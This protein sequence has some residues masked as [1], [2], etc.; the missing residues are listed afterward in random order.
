MEHCYSNIS[1]SQNNAKGKKPCT[2]VYRKF[3]SSTNSGPFLWNAAKRNFLVYFP[4]LDRKM[5]TSLERVYTCLFWSGLSP[6]ATMT[7]PLL[8]DPLYLK[9]LIDME[10]SW[11]V[12]WVCS[13]ITWLCSLNHAS[14]V[15]NRINCPLMQRPPQLT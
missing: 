10:K 9:I 8:I 11:K 3:K 2:N 4:F 13:D 5:T 15:E 14:P 1:E 6:W 7:Q 12:P